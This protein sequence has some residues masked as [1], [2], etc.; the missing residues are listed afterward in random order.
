MQSLT[1]VYNCNQIFSLALTANIEKANIKNK[2]ILINHTL[3]H[4]YR[5]LR[6]DCF[7]LVEKLFDARDLLIGTEP[8]YLAWLLSGQEHNPTS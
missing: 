3:L 2:K 6:C 5:K 4:V 1:Q 7:T 8:P